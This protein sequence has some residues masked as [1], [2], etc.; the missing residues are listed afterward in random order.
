MTVVFCLD[1]CSFAVQSEIRKVDSFS[2]I[3]LYQDY[4]S[5]LG[6]SVLPYDLSNFC[7]SSVKNAIGNLIE[8]ALNL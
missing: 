3:L 2:S 4:L 8:I 5:Y 1:D 6:S 7:S